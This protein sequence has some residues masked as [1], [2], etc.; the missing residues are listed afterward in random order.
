MGQKAQPE[1]VLHSLSKLKVYIRYTIRAEQTPSTTFSCSVVQRVITFDKWQTFNFFKGWGKKATT[2]Y[3]FHFAEHTV[4]NE[5]F[6]SPPIKRIYCSSWVKLSRSFLLYLGLSPLWFGFSWLRSVLLP[7]RVK[8]TSVWL[9]GRHPSAPGALR[10]AQTDR[11][12]DEHG[13]RGTDRRG[14]KGAPVKK[15]EGGR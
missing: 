11:K 4:P 14:P 2:H 13:D 12:T 8:V 7:E 9:I 15:R 10:R 5:A 3:V 6:L 1:L